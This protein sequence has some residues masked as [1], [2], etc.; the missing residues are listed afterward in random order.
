VLACAD[1]SVVNH[2]ALRAAKGATMHSRLIVVAA[3]ACAAA[4]P[5]SAASAKKPEGKGKSDKSEKVKHDKAEKVEKDKGEKVE[6]VKPGKAAK[7]QNLLLKGTVSAVDVAGNLVTVTVTSGN[8]GAQ[9]LAG[10][11]VQFN[12]S[13]AILQIT[14]STGDGVADLNDVVVGDEVMVHAQVVSEAAQ[15]YAA[16]QFKDQDVDTPVPAPD[17]LAG[18]P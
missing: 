16:K 5:V 14:D 18:T 7:G 3:A 9:A 4:F 17:P 12:V 1:V 15:P 10:Q 8:H 6:K 13:S 11:S 2:T